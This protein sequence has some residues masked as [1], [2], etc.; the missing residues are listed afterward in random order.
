[1][2]MARRFMDDESGMT[3]ALAIMMIVLIGVMGAGLLTFVS[4]DLNTVVEEN[5]GQRAFEMAD[6]GV[7]AAK[8]QLFSDCSGDTNCQRFYNDTSPTSP[9]VGDQDKQWSKVKGGLTLNNLDEIAGNGDNVKVEIQFT[10]SVANP[11]TFTVTSTGYYRNAIRKIEAKLNGVGGGG[12]GR[13]PHSQPGLL[14]A[15][16]YYD[17][18]DSFDVGSEFVHREKYRDKGPRPHRRPHQPTQGVPRRLWIE[19]WRRLPRRR[20]GRSAR[21]LGLSA[22]HRGADLEHSGAQESRWHTT[23]R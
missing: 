6:A 21:R 2:K 20:F 15:K 23:V 14:H 11:Y 7:N 1:M 3:M 22:P 4:R 8:R 17:R 13:W 16:R 9:F 5:K 12:G 19:W 18:W 10:G